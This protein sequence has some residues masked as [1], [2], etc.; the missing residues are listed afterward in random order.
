M[1]SNCSRGRR[2]GSDQHSRC[3]VA[4]TH[5]PGFS[6]LW[7]A[8][9]GCLYRRQTSRDD[10]RYEV[11]TR[12]GTTPTGLRTCGVGPSSGGARRGRNSDHLNPTGWR[13]LTGYDLDLT[14]QVSEAVSIPVIA[15]GGAG[16][17]AHFAEALSMGKASAVAAASIFYFTQ[18]TPLE[19][20][21]YLKE[22]NIEVR[23]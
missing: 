5:C 4:G 6:T 14:R 21:Q 10:G 18:Q 3:G 1:Y 16:C 7:H 11:Y 20:K 13:D 2:Q 22:Q 15:S 23:I 8:V 12:S 19:A 17:Y 9:C